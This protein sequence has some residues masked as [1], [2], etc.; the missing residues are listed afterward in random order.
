MTLTAPPAADSPVGELGWDQGGDGWP[1][2]GDW[3]DGDGLQD[4]GDRLDGEPVPSWVGEPAPAAVPEWVVEAVAQAGAGGPALVGRAAAAGEVLARAEGV[5]SA[6]GAASAGVLLG[7]AAEVSRV[8]R[9]AAGWEGRLV[10]SAR[11]AREVEGGAGWTV[12]EEHS[13]AAGL[14]SFEAQSLERAGRAGLESVE[15]ARAQD[16][17]LLSR[18][19]C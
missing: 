19:A 16:A 7:L 5:L 13:L 9:L 6:P 4:G 10:A 14:T 8:G 18:R 15:V 3:Q 1:G 11:A 12:V 17:G 2:G